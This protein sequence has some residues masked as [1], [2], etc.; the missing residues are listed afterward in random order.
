MQEVFQKSAN[1]V[2]FQRKAPYHG[3]MD[4]GTRPPTIES[5]LA[6]LMSD[7]TRPAPQRIEDWLRI[8]G[9]TRAAGAEEMNITPPTLRAA[10]ARSPCLA[11]PTVRKISKA[12]GIPPGDLL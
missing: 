11:A 7:S 4:T 1:A 5:V 2:D 6:E 12:T 10:L 8:K 3:A 9:L